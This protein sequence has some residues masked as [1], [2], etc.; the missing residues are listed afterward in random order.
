MREQEPEAVTLDL[1]LKKPRDYRDSP[2]S[3]PPPPPPLSHPTHHPVTVYRTAPP[4][5]D[6]SYY[7]HQVWHKC[8]LLLVNRLKIV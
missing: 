8:M 5:P 1:S 7:H 4:P 2:Q 3:K 6:P